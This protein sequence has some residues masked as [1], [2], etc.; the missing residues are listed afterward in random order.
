MLGAAAD[1]RAIFFAKLILQGPNK[2]QVHKH[3]LD[4]TLIFFDRV[5]IGRV[6]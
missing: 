1:M 4:L 3:T 2:R 6:N 5:F